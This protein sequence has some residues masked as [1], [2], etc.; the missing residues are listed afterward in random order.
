MAERKGAMVEYRLTDDRLIEAL[1]L[2]REVL[3]GRFARRASLLE[4][5]GTPAAAR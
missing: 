1:S 3:R 4:A 2:L 5:G